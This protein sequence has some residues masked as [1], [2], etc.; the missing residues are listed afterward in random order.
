MPL[1]PD[2]L[3]KLS[4]A[5]WYATTEM[6]VNGHGL[7]RKAIVFDILNDYT[8]D[9]SVKYTGDGFEVYDER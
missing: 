1:N 4:R 5:L 8:E 3:K 9:C 7:M 2:E 6:R